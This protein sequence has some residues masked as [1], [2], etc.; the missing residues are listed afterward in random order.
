MPPGPQHHPIFW[1]QCFGCDSIVPMSRGFRGRAVL[2][3]GWSAIRPMREGKR[4]AEVY[5]SPGCARRGAAIAGMKYDA[6][7][8][9]VFVFQPKP[10][11]SINI[12]M[13]A[14]TRAPEKK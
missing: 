5:A 6:D 14:I 12:E 13:S 7:N 4:L 3:A 8:V 11:T 9:D 2:P 10:I 1:V